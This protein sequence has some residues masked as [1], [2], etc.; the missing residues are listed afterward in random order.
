MGGVAAGT[1]IPQKKR[2]TKA[3]DFLMFVLRLHQWRT[4]PERW[5]DILQTKGRGSERVAKLASR[6]EL[7]QREWLYCSADRKSLSATGMTFSGQTLKRRAGSLIRTLKPVTPQ[8]KLKPERFAECSLIPVAHPREPPY[9]GAE[10][11]VQQPEYRQMAS[12]G[13]EHLSICNKR[14]GPLHCE[15]QLVPPRGSL[16]AVIEFVREIARVIGVE[17]ARRCARVRLIDSEERLYRPEDS[18]GTA[19]CGNLKRTT[20]V[21]G[22]YRC[23]GGG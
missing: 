20:R 19:I 4:C 12:C 10:L 7:E 11:S 6:T 23:L 1:A 9:R 14:S 22:Y 3:S 15:I 8:F 17:N 16:V 5:V 2:N 18:V 21:P 13:N